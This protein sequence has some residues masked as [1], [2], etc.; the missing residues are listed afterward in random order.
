MHFDSFCWFAVGDRRRFCKVTVVHIRQRKAVGEKED[1]ITIWRARVAARGCWGQ[2]KY[3]LVSRVVGYRNLPKAVEKKAPTQSS[4]LN[5]WSCCPSTFRRTI[6]LQQFTTQVFFP[7][8]TNSQT[9]LG[10]L[11]DA[12]STTRDH[13]IS[14]SHTFSVVDC[15]HISRWP[16]LSVSTWARR[17]L[18]SVF[19]VRTGKLRPIQI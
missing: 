6:L 17:T 13:I 5:S 7:F 19:S 1:S 16:P 15:T 2:S 8:L 14:H 10:N 18:A 12:F 4:C 11:R 9:T 3:L